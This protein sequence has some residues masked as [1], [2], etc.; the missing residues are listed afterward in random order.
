MLAPEWAELIDLR[1]NF[2]LYE[3]LR[4]LDQGLLR[5]ASV[6]PNTVA[7]EGILDVFDWDPLGAD[8]FWRVRPK[9]PQVVERIIKGIEL[10]AEKSAQMIILP[11]LCASEAEQAQI[12]AAWKA[13]QGNTGDGP[14][15]MIAG[16]YHRTVEP[17]NH[18]QNVCHIYGRSGA[19]S[20]VLKAV[21]F[22]H[23]LGGAEG[24]E[25]TARPRVEIFCSYRFTMMVFICV[26]F[27]LERL[28]DIARDLDVSLVVVPSMSGKSQVFR[29]LI[30]GH[31]AATQA[32]SIFVNV[33][34]STDE[35][36]LG[37]LSS[38]MPFSRSVDSAFGVGPDDVAGVAIFD[39]QDLKNL[40]NWFP[41][42]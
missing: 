27:L 1:L 41:L 5:V 30:D 15:L 22:V 32:T 31:V 34:K 35:Q 33:L 7:I 29:G 9:T 18:R 6:H 42:S 20:E 14:S 21:P 12:L 13:V 37:Y 36:S 23:D 24:I 39:F 16:S 28:R 19:Q 4:E 26:D 3:D 2:S 38:P 8:E 17:G 40:C 25:F 10:A 11:E